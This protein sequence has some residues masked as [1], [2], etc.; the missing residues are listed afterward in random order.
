[1]SPWILLAIA[2]LAEVAG[3]VALR[4]SDGFTRP[5]PSAIV[6]VAYSVAFYLLSIISRRLE[7]SIIYAVWSGAGIALLAL[8]GIV[9]LDERMSALKLASLAL[10]GVGIVGL[11]LA[12]AHR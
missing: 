6:L 8:I 3:T 11:N 9:A 1:M 2:V 12:G 4:Q 7:L 5:L 10:I